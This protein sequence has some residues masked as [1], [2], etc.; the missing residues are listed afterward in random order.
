MFQYHRPC[1]VAASIILLLSL[2]SR[3]L[4]ATTGGA[5]YYLILDLKQ[6]PVQTGIWQANASLLANLLSGA[7]VSHL[8]QGGGIVASLRFDSAGVAFV[9]PLAWRQLATFVIVG[10]LT[11]LLTVPMCY[12]ARAQFWRLPAGQVFPFSRLLHWYTDLRLSGRALGLEVL[13][14]LW[15]GVTWAVCLLPGL[16]VMLVA[17][18]QNSDTLLFLSGVLNLAGMAMG[19]F[20][21]TILLPGQ[22][23]LARSP[24]LTPITALRNGLRLLHGRKVEFFLLRLSFLPLQLLS[25]FLYDIPTLYLFPYLELSTILYLGA[26]EGTSAV[27]SNA[28]QKPN[29]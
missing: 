10:A 15:R 12:G 19:Y 2:L 5:L 1:M 22:Y 11:F 23:L 21:Y 13:L 16:L 14:L 24:E 3:F 8:T 28:P 9:L 17:T 18:Q 27:P 4:Q 25:I 6:Y 20:L 29:L 7:S 26:L